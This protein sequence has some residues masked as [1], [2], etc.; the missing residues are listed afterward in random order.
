MKFVSFPAMNLDKTIPAPVP[1]PELRDEDD[2]FNEPL[3]ERQRGA[4][5]GIVCEGGCE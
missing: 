2:D 1:K 5:D 3:G 4:N